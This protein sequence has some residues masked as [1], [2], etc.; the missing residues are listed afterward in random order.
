M[1]N[2]TLIPYG[3]R[4][5]GSSGYAFDAN[6]NPLAAVIEVLATLPATDSTDN[7]TGRTVFSEADSAVYIFDSTPSDTWIPLKDVP[8]TIGANAPSTTPA[9]GSM[10]YATSSKILYLRVASIW[11][12]IAG[13]LGSGVIW[14]HYTGNGATSRFSTGSTQTPPVEY[15]QVY[16]DG[17]AQQPGEDGVRD[18]YIVGNEV[19]LNTVPSNGAEISIRTL[20]YLQVT[21]NSKFRTTRTVANGTNN[22]FPTGVQGAE[23]GQVFVFLDGVAQIPDTGSGNGTYDYKIVQQDNSAVSVVNSSGTIA[24]LTSTVAHGL[25]VSDTVIV[26]G[27][28]QSEYNGSFTVASVPST[29]TLTYDMGAT[30][31]ATPASGDVTYGPLK[32]NDTVAFYNASGQ[33]TA[34]ETGIVVHIQSVEHITA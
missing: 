29:T 8:V 31:A 13:E 21:R 30:P 28:D 5:D 3:Q 2:P 12:A 27:A 15:V 24:T 22:S 16:I 1:P 34:P 32:Q 9:D 25:S 26:S 11:V 10:Y 4:T 17:V 20:V 33:A 14:R 7:F 23:A 18:Y 19:Q 6:G